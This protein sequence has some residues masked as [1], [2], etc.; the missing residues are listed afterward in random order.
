MSF[1]WTV[2]NIRKTS[3]NVVREATIEVSDGVS[4]LVFTANFED[5]NPTETDFIPYDNLTETN[6]VDWAKAQWGQEGIETAVTNKTTESSWISEP[7]NS[8]P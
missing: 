3:E 8:A 4:I 2:R 5:K 6:L 1:T 7:L